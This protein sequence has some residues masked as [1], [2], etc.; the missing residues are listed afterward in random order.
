MPIQMHRMVGVVGVDAARGC[1]SRVRPRSRVLKPG[2]IRLFFH[3]EQC[4]SL[5]NS[6]SIPPNHPN[7]SRIQTSEQALSRIGRD[8]DATDEAML[9]EARRNEGPDDLEQGQ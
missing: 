8:I 6:S 1:Q 7:S 5:T 2:L 3:L 9:D 4:F